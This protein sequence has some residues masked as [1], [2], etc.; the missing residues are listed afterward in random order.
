MSYTTNV[1]FQQ[2]LKDREHKAMKQKTGVVL[3]LFLKEMQCF[4]KLQCSQL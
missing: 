3:I 1:S 2:S 4:Y